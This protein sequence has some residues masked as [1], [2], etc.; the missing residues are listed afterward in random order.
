MIVH[1]FRCIV[2]EQ[3]RDEGDDPEWDAGQKYSRESECLCLS[4]RSDGG[5]LDLGG[6]VWDV[7][8]RVRLTEDRL[9]NSCKQHSNV[10][11]V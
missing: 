9:G 3:S 10:S 11:V 5:H 4:K 1:Q 7:L 2:N 8:E 6:D